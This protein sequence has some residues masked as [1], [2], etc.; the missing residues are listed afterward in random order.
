MSRDA[1]AAVRARDDLACG[2]RLTALSLA[3]FAGRG[4]RAFPGAAAAAQRA[5]L[6][7]SRYAQARDRL[8]RRG[9]VVVAAEASGRGRSSTLVPAFAQSGPRGIRTFEPQNRETPQPDRGGSAA[10]L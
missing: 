1:V 9:L 3:S 4:H 7:R 5:G 8:V 6:S 2:D 10:S